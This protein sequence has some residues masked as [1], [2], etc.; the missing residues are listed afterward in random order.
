MVVVVE[1]VEL[2]VETE[3]DVDVDE[4]ELIVELLLLVEDVVELLLLVDEELVKVELE[5]V[6]LLVVV[7]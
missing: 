4:L 3:D 5:L 1:D 2:V 6:V 7:D